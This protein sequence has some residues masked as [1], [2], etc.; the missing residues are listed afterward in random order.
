MI[1]RR[2]HCARLAAAGLAVAAL[3]A[4]C[5]AEPS[6]LG[7]LPSGT[8]GPDGGAGQ[9]GQAGAGG[10]DAGP[11]EAGADAAPDAQED[12]APDAAPPPSF[13]FVVFGDNQFATESC[14]S[15][16]PERLAVPEVVRSLSPTFVL[17]VGDLMDHGYDDG[18]YAKLVSCYEGM[19][20]ELPF[21]PTSGNHDMAKGGIWKYKAYLE[22]QLGTRNPS[23][24]PGDFAGDFAVAYEDDPTEYSTDFDKPTHLDDVPSG[25]SFKTFYA[26]RFQNAYFISFEQGTRWWTNTP[27][28]WVEKHLK[29]ARSAPGIEHVF[30][31]MHHPMYSV[32]ME[33][34]DPS[35]C[36]KPVRQAYEAL[37][38]DYD[39]TAVFSG[40]VHLYERFYV[41]DDGSPTKSDSPPSIYPHDGH[42]VHYVT[43]GG[44]GGPLPNNCSP[45]PAPLKQYSFQYLQA[46]RCGYH[47]T[48]VQ[49]E[50]KKLTLSVIGVT[51]NASDHTTELWD[52]I[53]VQ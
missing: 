50:G 2:G 18:A 22:E 46:R 25:V 14:T 6:D 37:V 15:G 44:G 13:S 20:A 40:H 34:T 12:A 4:G 31:T 36:V 51:G 7:L 3:G 1:E 43:T 48:R 16:V 5:E 30:V 28:S 10:A 11:S 27:R 33:E 42:A 24:W 17:S 52:E 39:V 38:R 26:V 29:A 8:S 49:V 45:I 53:V 35:E 32:K 21:F 9:G 23:V 41:P 19:L 47:V